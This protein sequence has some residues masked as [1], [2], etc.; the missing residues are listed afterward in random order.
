[1][2][3]Y[4]E[5][6]ANAQMMNKKIPLYF[7]LFQRGRNALP[8]RGGGVGGRFYNGFIVN[9]HHESFFLI[10]L[11]IFLAWQMDAIFSD[12]ISISEI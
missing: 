1:M 8:R 10:S 11:Q 7:P 9:R 4:T 12:Q 2:L 3:I 5:N 6:T